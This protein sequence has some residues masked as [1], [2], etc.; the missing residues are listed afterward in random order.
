MRLVPEKLRDRGLTLEIYCRV[1]ARQF[2]LEDPEELH[3]LDNDAAFV[4]DVVF[5]VMQLTAV[6]V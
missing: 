6:A 4:D 1:G 2:S 3:V 5:S